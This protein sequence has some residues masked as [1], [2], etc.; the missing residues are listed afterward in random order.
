VRC[1]AIAF[2]FEVKFC[3]SRSPEHIPSVKITFLVAAASAIAFLAPLHAQDANY[4][5]FVSD[6]H[7]GNLTV[8]SGS[9]LQPVATFPVG[10]R[11]RGIH[12]S[13]DGK[14]IYVAVSGTPIEAPPKLDANGN[15]I[16]AKGHDDD[17]DDQAKA[18][19]AA[20]GI[21]VV[22]V[23]SRKVL[24]KIPANSDPEQF[25]VSADGARLYIANEDS[26]VATILNVANDKIEHMMKVTREPEGVGVAPDG[27]TFY[28]TCETGG[29]CFCFDAATAKEL[30]HFTVH[31][32]PRSIDFLPDGSRAF[33]PSES[34][35]ELNIID[36]AQ[37]AVTQV[38]PL[39]KGARPQCIRVSPDGQKIYASG[40]RS[41]A[42]YVLSPSGQL[43]NTIPVGKR[44]WGLTLSPDGKR[45]FVANGP[46]EDVSVI[47]LATE[48][49]ITRVKCPGGPWGVVCVPSSN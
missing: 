21:I 1:H 26:G 28:V 45:L 29:D 23:A 20:D 17:D 42:V 9:D 38:V 8:I 11:P 3:I 49:E 12:A 15:P 7:S 34:S 10:K 32:R 4:Q 16:F 13:P 37:H 47:D 6:E 35:G 44:P 2:A 41:G 25:A 33:I 22:D 14:T 19:K 39:P 5:I 40:G 24:R 27:K 30:A 48:K 36:C 18:D 46:S 31:P 43:L